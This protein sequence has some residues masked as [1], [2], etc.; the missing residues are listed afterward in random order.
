[1]TN[2]LAAYF[3]LGIGIILLIVAFYFKVTWLF[4]IS[5]ASWMITGVYFITQAGTSEYINILGIFCTIVGLASIMSPSLI[6][7]KEPRIPRKSDTEQMHDETE[8]YRKEVNDYRKIFRQHT[9]SIH[10]Q[11]KNKEF[12]QGFGIIDPQQLVEHMMPC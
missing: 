5:A 6:R 8:A 2:F 4:M 11:L 1:M 10:N 7:Q 3:L 9:L 12:Y